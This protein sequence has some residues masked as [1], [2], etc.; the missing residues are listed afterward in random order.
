[1]QVKFIRRMNITDGISLKRN[2][3]YNFAIAWGKTDE[4]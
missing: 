2:G 4:L 3:E 1:M